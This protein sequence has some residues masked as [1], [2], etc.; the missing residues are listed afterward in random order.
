MATVVFVRVTSLKRLADSNLLACGILLHYPEDGGT[1]ILHNF[2]NYESFYTG[3]HLRKIIII[4]TAVVIFFES[5]E[6][7][8]FN[9]TAF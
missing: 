3:S 2:E 4:N 8:F 7:L 1:K 5:S 6:L 9:F